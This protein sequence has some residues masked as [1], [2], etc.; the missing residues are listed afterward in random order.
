MQQ[1]WLA[2][3]QT[4]DPQ[5]RQRI[6]V[7]MANSHDPDA[8]KILKFLYEHDPD[9][10]NR[11]MAKNAAL[12]LWHALKTPQP[13][14]SPTA[15]LVPAE[16]AESVTEPLETI[17]P[18]FHPDAEP[19]LKPLDNQSEKARIYLN[20][21]LAALVKE[22]GIGAKK[23]LIQ[24]I[25]LNPFL[26]DDQIAVNLA[27]EITGLAPSEAM[28][29]IR[30]KQFPFPKQQVEVVKPP[31][32]AQPRPQNGL[33][34]LIAG[35]GIIAVV[36]II[37]LI[38]GTLKS[39]G[40]FGYQQQKHTI[41]GYTYYLIPPE[42]EAPETGWP[43]VVALHEEGGKAGD[44]LP[45]ARQFTNQGILFVAPSLADYQPYPGN[46]PIS[47]MEAILNQV[48][49]EYP[50]RNQGMV[51]LGFSQ[52]GSFAWRYSILK[53]ERIGGVVS[54]GV[55][56]LDALVPNNQALPYIFTWGAQETFQDSLVPDLLAPLVSQGYNVKVQI[57]PNTG[58]VLTSEAVSLAIQMAT[59]QN[60]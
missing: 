36:I 57:I 4:D 35:I 6:I 32:P 60:P 49:Q 15:D 24:A 39:L 59:A 13:D 58:H 48:D 30:Q 42:T 14:P 12:H 20:R 23:A 8:L 16:E 19:V 3:L 2:E 1:D 50:I 29:A 51:L 11:G 27:S 52:G 33:M 53:P 44:V 10:T 9:E 7:A 41:N 31:E 56:E 37:F 43:V 21:A 40:V 18:E 25:T 26:Q 5:V 55:S 22:D 47:P 45:L 17:T 38:S 34:L 46:G 54:A 28:E